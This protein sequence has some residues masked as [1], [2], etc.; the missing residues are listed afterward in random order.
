MDRCEP[1]FEL[2]ISAQAYNGVRR[3]FVI[4]D[5]YLFVFHSA[6]EPCRDFPTE[7]VARAPVN[8]R[9]QANEAA[10]QQLSEFWAVSYVF[11]R[12]KIGGRTCFKI[13]VMACG[14]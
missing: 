3:G 14:R 12:K 11:T 2:S 5:M 6:P 7:R 1:V 9:D 4:T 10:E 13:C 8:D